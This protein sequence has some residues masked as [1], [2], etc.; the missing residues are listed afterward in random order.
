[1]K[2]LKISLS[3]V[4]AVLLVIAAVPPAADAVSTS[5]NFLELYP[6]QPEA[7][8]NS[9]KLE[10]GEEEVPQIVDGTVYIPLK[11]VAESLGYSVK[12]NEKTARV[13]MNTPGFHIEIDIAGKQIYVNKV[14]VPFEKLALMQNSTLLVKLSWVG[15][16]MGGKYSFDP[17][18]NRIEIIFVQRPEGVYNDKTQESKPVAK[19]TFGKRSYR[20][21]EPVKYIDLS[22]DTDAEG[23][24]KYEWTGKQDAFFKAGTYPVSLRVTDAKGK[25]SDTYTRNI[26]IEDSTYMDEFNYPLYFADPGTFIPA[27]WGII[28]EHYHD[29][30]ELT[31]SVTY[32]KERKL[33]VSDSPEEIKQKGILYQDVVKGK[34]RLYA[35]HVNGMIEKIQFAILVTNNTGKP[36][37]IH[38]TNKGEVYPSSYANLIGHEASVDF[39]LHDPMDEKLV[40]PPNRTV[41]YV[42]MP[43]FYPSQGVNAFYDVETDGEVTF[44]FLAMDP[45]STPVSLG[46]YKPLDYVANVRGTFDAADVRWDVDASSFDTPSRL[47]IGDGESDAFVPGYDVQRKMKVT[48]DGNYGVIYSIHAL[49]PR[50]MVILLLP[51]GGPFKG[52]F[53]INGNFVMAP[54]SGLLPAFEGVQVLARTTGEEDSLDIEFTPPAGS[55]FPIDLIF[56]PLEDKPLP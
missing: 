39:M 37:T 9:D 32:D 2:L 12:W 38:T 52:P 5:T 20:I 51:R 24:K 29:L 11:F 44:S 40:V 6:G 33:I 42:Q 16:Y 26:T 19:F 43:D 15:D 47:V 55:A 27:D 56:Y 50:K 28:W 31:R 35:D 53:K 25:V 4:L 36:V 46:F 18:H 34:A 7:F 30:P 1:M 8:L 45:I 10:I 23:I 3:F 14:A 49:H 48:D 54:P 13:E 21:G 17:E 41:V 22:Y